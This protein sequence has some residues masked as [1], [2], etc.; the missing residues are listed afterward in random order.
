VAGVGNGAEPKWSKRGD[1]LPGAR[2]ASVAVCERHLK[3][4]W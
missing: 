2:F 1:V 3:H 4:R